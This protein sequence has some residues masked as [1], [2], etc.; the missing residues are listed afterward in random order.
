MQSTASGRCEWAWT[1]APARGTEGWGNYGSLPRRV[2]Q[3]PH[4]AA[5]QVAAGRDNKAR[6][7]PARKPEKYFSFRQLPGVPSPSPSA[8]FAGPAPALLIAKN[9][10][11]SVQI[12]ARVFLHAFFSFSCVYFLFSLFAEM[13]SSPCCTCCAGSYV[14]GFSFRRKFA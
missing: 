3:L 8:S 10:F 12:S 6:A 7:C 1:H 4:P 5:A 2:A 14:A 11:S 9:H 13:F